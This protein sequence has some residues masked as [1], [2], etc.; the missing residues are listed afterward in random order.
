MVEVIN[1][2]NPDEVSAFLATTLVSHSYEVESTSSIV[3]LWDDIRKIVR[4]QNDLDYI[5]AILATG[6][7]TL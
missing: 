6:R 1:T 4:L 2:T 7:I 5:A 3:N